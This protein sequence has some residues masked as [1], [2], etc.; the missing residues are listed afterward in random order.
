MI[1][2]L[3]LL[4][5]LQSPPRAAADACVAARPAAAPRAVIV[6]PPGQ[7]KDTLLRATV[8]IVPATGKAAAIG[9][10][11]GE[12]HFDSTAASV[13]SVEK[14]AGGVRV[15][16]A[17]LKGQVNFAGAAPAGFPGRGLVT[18]VLKLRRPGS[19]PALRL[20]MKELNS[21]DGKSM[22]KELVVA[23]GTP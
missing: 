13:V 22:M 5:L 9:S 1:A 3:L 10:Y 12:L 20:T 7:G 23:R 4:A 11:H 17:A 15:E 18:V 2:P 19:A 6:V 8:C 16:N 21:T 14:A